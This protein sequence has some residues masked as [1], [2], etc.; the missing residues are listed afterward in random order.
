M[1]AAAGTRMRRWP[2][3]KAAAQR[4]YLAPQ[5]SA[6]AGNLT[7]Q[8]QPARN[9]AAP[10]FRV[11]YDVGSAEYFA[12]W[13]GFAAWQGAELRAAR[14]CEPS[15]A[16]VGFP[17]VHLRVASDRPE[18]LLFAYLEQVNPDGSAT[19]LAFG[20]QAAA[21]RKT[22]KA[23]YDTLGLPWM[24]GLCRGFRAAGAGQGGG[25]GFPAD[26]RCRG[27]CRP[28]ARLRLVVT[29][30]DP[31]QRNLAQLKLDPPPLDHRGDRRRGGLLG[32]A[33]AAAQHGS[34]ASACHRRAGSLDYC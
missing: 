24:T 25:G 13:I 20:R 32:R 16:M 26:G 3:V 1:A 11:N 12:F 2:G 33:A 18:P 9:A 5:S 23:P 4:V 17:V 29:G 22:G 7:L 21:M 28:A 6:G 31:R 15:A 10:N 30:A 14:R 8:P 19:V 34:D 27:W